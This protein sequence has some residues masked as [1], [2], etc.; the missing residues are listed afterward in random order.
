MPTAKLHRNQKGDDIMVK[1]GN[2]RSYLRATAAL[3]FAIA[4]LAA[5]QV[6]AAL[7]A[8]PYTVLYTFQGSPDGAFPEGGLIGD[9]AGNLYGTAAKGGNT[10]CDFSAGCGT[11][12]KLAPDGT[13][14]VLYTFTGGSDGGE[15]VLSRLALDGKGNLYGTT[16][17]GGANGD[18]VVFNISPNGKEE[19]LY[20][21]TNGNDGGKP[22]GGVIRDKAGNLYGT[23]EH[24]GANGSGTVFKLAKTNGGGYSETVLHSFGPLP[25]AELPFGGV[26]EDEAGNLFGATNGGGANLDG[27]VY[28]IAPDG[29]ETVLHSFTGGS[30]GNQ[31]GYE[32]L[33]ED[34]SG[35]LYGTT[36][37]GGNQA[38]SQGCGTVFKVTPGGTETVLYAFTGYSDGM[39]PWSG[40]SMDG[41][42]NLYGTTAEGGNGGCAPDGSCG[43]VYKLT[44]AG[45]HTVLYAFTGG[46]DGG[47]PFA[48]LIKDKPDGKGELFGTTEI[49]GSSRSC[50]QGS[51]GCGVVFEIEK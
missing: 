48:P 33:I 41:K 29:T 30:D 45:R 19:V 4:A 12:F 36:V 5:A 16:E 3:P 39:Y 2:F 8:A 50:L 14:A 11:V 31:P 51:V 10:G 23:T 28:K 37:A 24:G 32:S 43:T 21:F 44:P 25:D 18:G 38:C 49:A 34:S 22:S 13:E 15:P 7:A 35:N 42:G 27:A 46:S 1:F 9:K 17:E 26:I 20:S 47:Y 6:S 40:V